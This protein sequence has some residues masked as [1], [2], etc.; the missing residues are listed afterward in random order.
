[1]AV[2]QPG[3]VSPPESHLDLLVVTRGA[4]AGEDIDA[5]AANLTTRYSDMVHDVGIAHV[6]R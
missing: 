4:T 5:C 3:G 1:M 2:S 6:S